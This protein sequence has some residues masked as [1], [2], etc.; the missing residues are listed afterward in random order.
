MFWLLYNV[1]ASFINKQAD[2]TASFLSTQ[3]F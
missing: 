2:L 3:A 1:K